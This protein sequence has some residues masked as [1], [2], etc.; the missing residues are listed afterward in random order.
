MIP[1]QQL[2]KKH[3]V[4]MRTTIAIF[5]ITLTFFITGGCE[6]E[7]T[8]YYISSDTKAWTLFN[9]GSYWIYRNDYT[10]VLDSTVVEQPPEYNFQLSGPDTDLDYYEHIAV[11]YRSALISTGEIFSEGAGYAKYMVGVSK[12]MYVTAY[13]SWAPVDSVIWMWGN[14]ILEE[15]LYNYSFEGMIF[16]EV[17]HTKFTGEGDNLD[18]IH[19]ILAKNVGLIKMY[20]IWNDTTRSWSLIRYHV[21]QD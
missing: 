7:R 11:R 12:S 16:P 1:V 9:E 17:L 21:V 19:F 2:K 5:A 14:F 15:K 3:K 13:L 20:G 6:E 8:H 10:L 4:V 18:T